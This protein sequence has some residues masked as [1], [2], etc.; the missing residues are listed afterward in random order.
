MTDGPTYAAFLGT[1]ILDPGSCR[2][3]Q[4][5]PPLAGSYRIEEVGGRLHFQM[6]W[7]AADGSSHQV[8]FS[9]VPD[10]RREPFAGG[11]LADA[12]SVHAVSPRELTSAAYHGGVERMVAQRQLN[13]GGNAMRVIQLVRF[14]DGSSLANVS[15]YLR[16]VRN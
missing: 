8:R 9:G 6:E 13:A 16:Q 10:G 4:G 14:L 3:E 7:T 2:Y 5:E 15:V 1:W 11:E 12:L